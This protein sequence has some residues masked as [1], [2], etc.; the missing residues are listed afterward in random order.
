MKNQK[1]HRSEEKRDEGRSEKGEDKEESDL[2]INE[3]GSTEI[4]TRTQNDALAM[5]PYSVLAMPLV[6]SFAR[7]PWS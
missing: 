3:T 6:T 2:I 5:P 4:N 1:N 7:P